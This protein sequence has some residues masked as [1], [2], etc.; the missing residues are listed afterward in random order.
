MSNIGSSLNYNIGNGVNISY[1]N[2]ILDPGGKSIWR[3]Q[4]NNS[5]LNSNKMFTPQGHQLP[6][7]SESKFVVPV[8]NSMFYFNKNQVS[9]ACCPSTYTTDMGCVCTTPEQRHFIG[10]TRGGNKN[11][12]TYPSI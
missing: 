12:P 5:S 1:S 10:E 11:Y 4:P 3:H 7:A 9:M 2:K 8:N 6:L